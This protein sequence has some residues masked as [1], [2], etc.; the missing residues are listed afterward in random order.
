MRRR[1][2]G[3]RRCRGSCRPGPRP[4]RRVRAAAAGGLGGGNDLPATVIPFLLRGVRLLGIDSVRCP[5]AERVTAWQRL[6]ADLPA[7]RLDAMTETVPL[8]ALPEL[9]S[10]ILKGETRGRV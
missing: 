3:R 7:D 9:A 2:G 5:M 10:R 4:N 6:A 1:R 8:G